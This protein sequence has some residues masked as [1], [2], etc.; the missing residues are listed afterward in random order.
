MHKLEERKMVKQNVCPNCKNCFPGELQDPNGWWYFCMLDVSK[1]DRKYVNEEI[2]ERGGYIDDYGDQSFTPKLL[3]IMKV[4]EQESF[5]DSPR[6][7]GEWACC[8]FFEDESDHW[9]F[10]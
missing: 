6:E 7:V 5:T 2:T 1:E 9:E 10:G 3:Q 8:Q 4:G